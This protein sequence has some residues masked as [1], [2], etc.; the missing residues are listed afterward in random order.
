LSGVTLLV[1][2]DGK[3]DKL[4]ENFNKDYVTRE[5]TPCE[6]GEAGILCEVCYLEYPNEYSDF[7]ALDCEHMFCVNCV[8]EHLK[9]A[10]ESSKVMK[11][12]CMGLDCKKE[13]KIAEIQEFCSVAITEKYE[14]IRE[15]VRVGGN[16]NLKW[17][18]NP[19]CAMPLRKPG[20]CKGN[21][22]RCV[23]QTEMCFKCGEKWHEGDC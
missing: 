3:E 8:A 6:E 16:K 12:P 19:T 7:F 20:C 2:Q 5:A 10:I 1:A 17:C 18:P 13:F 14:N 21:R 11:I 9:T 22:V 4:I 23:C 15:D